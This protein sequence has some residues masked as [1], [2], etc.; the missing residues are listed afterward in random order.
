MDFCRPVLSVGGG[1]TADL[2]EKQKRKENCFLEYCLLWCR[3]AVVQKSLLWVA[4]TSGLRAE[5]ILTLRDH[6]LHEGKPM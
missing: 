4:Q 6:K 1:L 2:S 5:R 3:E